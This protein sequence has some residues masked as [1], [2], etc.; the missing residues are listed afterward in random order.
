MT[1]HLAQELRTLTLTEA[2]ACL[3]CDACNG[4][5]IEE[6]SAS[7][8]W[9]NVADDVRLNGGDAKWGLSPEQAAALVQRLQQ[10]TPGQV[11]ALADAVERFWVSPDL[12]A[13]A[14][15]DLLRAVGLAQ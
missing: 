12:N 1:A 3:I 8:L 2:E 9:A 14:T 7:F 10:L 15:P 6:H 5:W 4:W 11:F 13:L